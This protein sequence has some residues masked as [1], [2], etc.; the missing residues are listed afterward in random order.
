M[1]TK[2]DK[3]FSAESAGSRFGRGITCVDQNRDGYDDILIGAATYKGAPGRVY[4]FNG[5][6][7]PTQDNVPD[8]TFDEPPGQSFYGTKII[9]GDID[10]DKHNDIIVEARLFRRQ[11]RVYVYW[12]NELSADDVKLGKIFTGERSEDFVTT[13]LACGD[14]NNDGYD[15]L[16]IKAPV[17]KADSEHGQ[18]Y[19]YYGGPRNK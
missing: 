6:A 15:D 2:S 5:N 19:L 18:V 8:K 11:A 7:R 16:F 17:F 14:M 12:G 10:G 9:T 1:D 4:L 13:G 3:I